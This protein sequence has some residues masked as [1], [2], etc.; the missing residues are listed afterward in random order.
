MPPKN[1]RATV[2]MVEKT[3]V[4]L[5]CGGKDVFFPRSL[6]PTVS[7][8]DVVTITLAIDQSTSDR[9]GRAAEL[10]DMTSKRVSSRK[11]GNPRSASA[12]GKK[13]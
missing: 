1:L 6:L 2:E 3:T 12:R 10:D 13:K 11:R 7:E 9:D 5:Q 8:G 4:V